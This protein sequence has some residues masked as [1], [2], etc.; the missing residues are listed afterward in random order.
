MSVAE[1]I[2][3]GMGEG[4]PPLPGVS[5]LPASPP[6]P[7]I[8]RISYTHDAMIDLIIAN[9]AISGNELALHFG[10]SAAWISTVRHSDAFAARLAQRRSEIVDPQ[11]VNSVELQFKGIIHRSMEVLKEKLSKEADEVSDSTCLR[12]LEL[13]SRALGYGAASPPQVNVQV[14]VDQHL[15]N[16]AGNLTKLLQRKKEQA[17]SNTLPVPMED[18]GDE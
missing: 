9:P 2:L 3:E 1:Q 7:S 18:D 14:N 6:K 10:Y 4:S 15:E 11:L 5:P 12:A 13:S 16:M 17:E 8:K